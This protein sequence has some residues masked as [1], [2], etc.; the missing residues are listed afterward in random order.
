MLQWC[1]ECDDQGFDLT[2]YMNNFYVLPCTR[3]LACYLNYSKLKVVTH[4]FYKFC[5]GNSGAAQTD[6][7]SMGSVLTR[8]GLQ[9]FKK[10]HGIT[11]CGRKVQ[12]NSGLPCLLNRIAAKPGSCTTRLAQRPRSEHAIS[13][14]LQS[15]QFVASLQRQILR[16]GDR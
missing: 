1:Y 4:F 7:L 6:R 9:S 10:R 2:L 11:F 13:G 14:M 3:L 15:R 12:T 5:I 8:L 16:K